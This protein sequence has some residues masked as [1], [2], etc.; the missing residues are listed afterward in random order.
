MKILFLHGWQSVPGGVKPTYLKDHGHE[1]LNPKLPDDDFAQAVRIAQTEFDTHRPQIVVGSSRGGAVA[2]NIDSGE[3]KIVLLCPAWKKYGTVKTVKPGT[4]ILHSQA[5][6]VVPFADSEELARTSG[7]ML[8]EVGSDHRL[9][10]PES[11]E[12][13][14]EACVVDDENEATDEDETDILE[15][16]WTGLC[17][18][19]ALRWITAAEEQ[20]WVVVHGT[21]LSEK[22]GKRIGHAWCE[23]GDWVVDL[24][25]PVDARIIEKERYYRAVKP[26]V[27]KVYS[28]EDAL[29]LSIKTG[30]QGPW[31]ESEQLKEQ[32]RWLSTSLSPPAS[33]TP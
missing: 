10:D 21:V 7:A 26:E 25:M 2:M 1:V 6:D 29:I 33:G 24:A 17:Y 12:T 13:M 18:T 30:H 20:D 11:L 19:A 8:I 22:V 9:A 3:A 14:L 28:S 32:A 27:S 31:D 4:V 23:R 5:D 16:D 15:Q